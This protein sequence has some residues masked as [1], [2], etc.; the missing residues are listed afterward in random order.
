MAD[1]YC[2][3]PFVE[4]RRPSGDYFSSWFEATQA[5]YADNQIWSV[6]L[7][8]ETNACTYGPPRHVVNVIGYVATNERHDHDT[9]FHEA[10]DHDDVV[11]GKALDSAE[12]AFKAD[13]KTTS[14]G[15]YL[16]ALMAAERDGTIDDDDFFDGLTVL[17]D[18]LIDPNSLEKN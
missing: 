17:C 18:W 3:F 15:R 16:G 11:S 8:D 14:A 10:E 6:V 5:G 7:D 4:F 2:D 13:P 1:N 12:A 9:Y